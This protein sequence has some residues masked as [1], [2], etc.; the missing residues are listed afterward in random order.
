MT[1]EKVKNFWEDRGLIEGS[2]G[3]NDIILQKIEERTLLEAVPK[4]SYVCDIGCGDGHA[5]HRL[6]TENGCTGI[7]VDYSENFIAQCQV[8]YKTPALKFMCKDIRALDRDI[9]PF[10]VVM[11]KRCLINLEN[12]DEQ[13]HIFGKILEIVKPGGL[14]IMIE[15]FVDGNEALNALREPLG[16][17]RME[18]PWHNVYLRLPHVQDWEKSFP[19]Q[20]G[21]VSHFSSTYYFLSRVIN[22]KLAQDRGE[23]PRYDS[24]I[25]MLALNLPPFGEFGATKM[26]IWKKKA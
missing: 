18:S 9:G 20:L 24:D 14:Y 16:L 25:N 11:S 13:K 7:G 1:R 26:L 5:L 22:A 19:V 12:E 23:E 4:N 6:H 15:S 8:Y 17:T 3:T 10:D 2:G 21:Q